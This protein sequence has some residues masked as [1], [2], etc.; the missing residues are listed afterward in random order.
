MDRPTWKQDGVSAT[1]HFLKEAFT[2]VIEKTAPRRKVVCY[3]IPL[4]VIYWLSSSPHWVL[5]LN[6]SFNLNSFN[7]L[8]KEEPPGVTSPAHL[9]AALPKTSQKKEYWT[10]FAPPTSKMY[11]QTAINVNQLNHAPKY[12]QILTDKKLKQLFC[13]KIIVSKLTEQRP[14]VLNIWPSM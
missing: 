7:G 10:E 1:S 11:Q 13:E 5:G 3:A 14:N 6:I 8:L 4:T 2:R 9:V 12:S